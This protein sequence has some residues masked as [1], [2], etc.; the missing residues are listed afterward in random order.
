MQAHLLC[1][2]P[3]DCA[4]LGKSGADAEAGLFAAASSVSV[5]LAEL[6]R[7][8]AEGPLYMASFIDSSC[9]TQVMSCV[10]LIIFFP[11]VFYYSQHPRC[12]EC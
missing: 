12:K 7:E 3:S 11:R 9:G 4:L 2:E 6:A 10:W 5:E 8:F 1:A